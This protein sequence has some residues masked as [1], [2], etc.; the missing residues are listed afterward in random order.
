ML[1]QPPSRFNVF[2]VGENLALLRHVFESL[3]FN[4]VRTCSLVQFGRRSIPDAATALLQAV[5]SRAPDLL[6][7]QWSPEARQPRTRPNIRTAVEFLSGVVD[8]QLETGNKVILEGRAMDIPVRDEVFENSRALGK[9]L[10]PRQHQ[11]WCQHGIKNHS[12]RVIC[13]D[14]LVLSSPSWPSN[15]CVC[16]RNSS[17]Y[18]YT[19]GEGYEQF[20][21]IALAHLKMVSPGTKPPVSPEWHENQRELKSKHG[22]RDFARSKSRRK[23]KPASQEE[24][25]EKSQPFST[26]P[27]TPRVRISSDSP[28]DLRISHRRGR[29]SKESSRN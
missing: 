21:L 2:I 12:G 16:S 8:L 17:E 5:K 24:N 15:K 3:S 1:T 28:R 4:V 10:G 13:G 25:E 20:I 27:D 23:S 6:W 19:K 9:L 29:K 26:F 22:A 11:Y 18:A 7:I 14:H